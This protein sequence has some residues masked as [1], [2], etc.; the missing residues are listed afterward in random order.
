MQ[1]LKKDPTYR[2]INDTAKRLRI[3]DDM[4]WEES[5]DAAVSKRKVLLARV[6]ENWEMEDDSESDSDDDHDSDG[7]GDADDNEDEDPDE[8]SQ[9]DE[10]Y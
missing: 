10:E 2:K 4:D 8:D 5:I 1:S 3:E 6:L 9:S 7:D